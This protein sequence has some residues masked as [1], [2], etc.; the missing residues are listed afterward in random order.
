MREFTKKH[1]SDE[2]LAAHKK[3]LAKRLLPTYTFEEVNLTLPVRDERNRRIW[4]EGAKAVSA[5]QFSTLLTNLPK[6]GW[7]DL[8][9]E[10]WGK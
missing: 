7:I 10:D 2:R 5:E 3:R 1:F 6:Q 8:D 9:W 4:H